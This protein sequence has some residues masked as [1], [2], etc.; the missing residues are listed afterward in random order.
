[1]LRSRTAASSRASGIPPE[2]LPAGSEDPQPRRRLEQFPGQPGAGLDEVLAGVEHEQDFPVRQVR[3]ELSERVAGRL[4]RQAEHRRHGAR[5]QL[6]VAQRGQ[7][8]QPAAVR[9]G[10]PGQAG[11]TQRQAGLAHAARAAQRD[12]PVPFDRVR[13]RGKLPPPADEP[14]DL[15]R[16]IVSSLA[17]G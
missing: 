17:K 8:D 3:R 14:G 10:F 9:E 2:R 4:V 12:Q 1:M 5:Q 15:S 6:G 16:K 7:L 11:G 13:D